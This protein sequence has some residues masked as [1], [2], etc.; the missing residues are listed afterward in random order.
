MNLHE[1]N[2]GVEKH[3]RPKRIGRGPG[4]G[5]GKT[6][7]KGHKGQRSHAGWSS[8]SIFTG[9]GSPLV[10]RV[11]KRGFNNFEFAVKVSAVNVAELEKL[12]ESGATV[13]PDDLRKEN[14]AKGRFDELKILGNGELT[15][16]LI[17][18]AHRFSASAKE[19]IE[20]AGGQCVVIPTKTTVA[21]KKAAAKAAKKAAGGK[22]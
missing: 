14:L 13:T 15:K 8:P 5:Q 11:P 1:V 19:K 10:R 2:K 7:G 12:F 21:E 6:A 4:S 18:N 3:R 16:K 17:V 20:K 9:G 22:K